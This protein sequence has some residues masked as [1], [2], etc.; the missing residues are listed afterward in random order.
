MRQCSAALVSS[1]CCSLC[2]C[3]LSP[4]L[5]PDVM[6]WS[7]DHVIQWVQSIGLAEYAPNLI[8]SGV[9]GGV[10]AL[11]NGYDH[12]KLALALKIPLTNP[13]VRG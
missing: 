6:V 2:T 3:N 4:S 5:P 10:F 9:H 13:E 11:D 1:L 7:N 8:E 12:Q